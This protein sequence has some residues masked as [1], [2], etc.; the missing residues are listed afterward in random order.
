MGPLESWQILQS[1]GILISTATQSNQRVGITDG[2]FDCLQG[3]LNIKIPKHS[4]F[5]CQHLIFSI[6][7]LYRE[8]LICRHPILKFYMCTFAICSSCYCSSKITV[9]FFSFKIFLLSVFTLSRLED[10]K[11][12]SDLGLDGVFRRILRFPPLLTTG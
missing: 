7:V 1:N 11:V 9:V 8:F 3:C 12:A 10:E 4:I 5:I 2:L 6:T